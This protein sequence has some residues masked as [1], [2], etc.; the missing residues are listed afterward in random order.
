MEI[1]EK[2]ELLKDNVIVFSANRTLY[3]IRALKD[4]GDVKKG[5]LGGYIQSEANLSHTGNCWIYSNAR[6]Y[7]NAVVYG[8]AIISGYSSVYENTQIYGY[9][10]IYEE[11]RIYGNA[12]IH[13]NTQIFGRAR[14]SGNAHIYENAQISEYVLISGDTEIKRN[15]QIKNEN[16]I[17]WMSRFGSEFRTTTVFR[18]SEIP[19]GWRVVCGCF[20]GSVE[21]F[22]AQI[23]KKYPK[24]MIDYSFRKE[25]KAMVMLIK[26]RIKRN[27]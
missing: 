23:D 26:E 7:D 18:D 25:Y 3:R 16:D 19:G 17:F 14:I 27:A 8:N 21:E 10:R 11:A 4:F 22:E 2:Y 12:Q 20:T 6:V 13:G 24:T 15:A 5:D 9:A 1:I